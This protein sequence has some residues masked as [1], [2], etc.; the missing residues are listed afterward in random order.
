MAMFTFSVGPEL[1]TRGLTKLVYL[2]VRLVF[3]AGRIGRLV[4][5]KNYVTF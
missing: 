3:F 5:Q 1:D 4:Y 2:A